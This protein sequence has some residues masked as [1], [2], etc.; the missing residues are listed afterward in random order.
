M[1]MLRIW[2]SQCVRL[3][4]CRANQ[5]K[6]KAKWRNIAEDVVWQQQEKKKRFCEII[7]TVYLIINIIFRPY[8]LFS[9]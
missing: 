5:K 9:L 2:I 3:C 8:R 7:V 4:L 1:Y 6:K